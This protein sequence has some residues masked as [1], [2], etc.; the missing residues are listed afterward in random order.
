[1][2]N[3]FVADRFV[4]DRFAGDGFAGDKF[5]GRQVC[6][7]SSSIVFLIA[8]G[9]ALL[10][11]SSSTLDVSIVQYSVSVIFDGVVPTEVRVRTLLDVLF[12]GVTIG[13]GLMLVC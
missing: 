4:A 9:C 3:R 8:P 10:L 13:R 7:L 6:G 12:G 1:V 5:Y 2:A 11:S